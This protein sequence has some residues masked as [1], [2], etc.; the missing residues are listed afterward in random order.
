MQEAIPGIERSMYV[1]F[2]HSSLEARRGFTFEPDALES[3][4]G[5]TLILSSKDDALSRHSM[6]RL[7]SRYP[8]A[9]TELLEEGGHHAFLFFPEAYT[10]ALRAFLDSV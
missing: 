3:W 7:Q 6:E 8:R 4:P 9:R 5:S 2:L 1:G 10:A